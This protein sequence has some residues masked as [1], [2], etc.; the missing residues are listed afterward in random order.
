MKRIAILIIIIVL[1]AGGWYIYHEYN[2]SNKDLKDQQ[3]AVTI[4]AEKLIAAFQQDTAS[5]SM[6]FIDKIIAV[7]GQVK[8]ID[9]NGNPV[10]IALGTVGEM[11]SVQCSMDSTYAKEYV[12]IHEGAVIKL[13]G[14]CTGGKTEDLFGTDV[15]LN[16]CVLDRK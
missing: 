3:P 2:R 11:S 5:A 8:M 13:K 7:S 6:T 16:R 1:A 15:I 12:D 4:T 9:R 14:I 10:V